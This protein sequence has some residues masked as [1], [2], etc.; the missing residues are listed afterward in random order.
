M[1]L[2]GPTKQKEVKILCND[3]NVGLIDLLETR[4]KYN[5]VE[6]VVNKIFGGWQFHS[7]HASHYNGRILILWRSDYYKLTVLSENA[8]AITC[9]AIFVPLQMELLATFV[10]PYN[11]REERRELWEYICHLSGMGHK[12]WI[13][14]GDFNSMLHVE[15][16]QGG[17]PVTLNEVIDFQSCLM[18]QV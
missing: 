3:L 6:E 7:N 4:I 17:N 8:Q 5:K 10:Y 2:N 12:P 18:Q 9:A 13:P 1:G 15:D 14:I 16:R 11:L